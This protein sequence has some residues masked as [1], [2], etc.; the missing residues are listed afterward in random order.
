MNPL[1]LK[2]KRPWGRARPL[3]PLLEKF[4]RASPRVPFEVESPAGWP[5]NDAHGFYVRKLSSPS[6]NQ[7]PTGICVVP[8]AACPLPLPARPLSSH[9]TRPATNFDN[10]DIRIEAGFRRSMVLSS[11]FPEFAES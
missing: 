7:S 9:D 10:H 4:A 6:G 3:P 1:F 8:V 5:P 11:A 2:V